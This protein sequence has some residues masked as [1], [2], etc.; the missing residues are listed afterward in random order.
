MSE[1]LLRITYMALGIYTFASALFTTTLL[2][3]QGD[4]P[5][6][7]FGMGCLWVSF[8]AMVM[9]VTWASK[10]QGRNPGRRLP[11][12]FLRV[13]F[14][15]MGLMFFSC[16]LATTLAMAG[17][18][19]SAPDLVAVSGLWSG[20]LVYAGV[21][22]LSQQRGEGVSTTVTSAAPTASA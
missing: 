12:S 5:V 18:V 8:I 16:A 14:L 1:S 7:L 17:A 13:S 9:M 19:L 20:F 4:E 2:S 10:A 6:Q 21:V 15:A 3:R 22:V 11:E